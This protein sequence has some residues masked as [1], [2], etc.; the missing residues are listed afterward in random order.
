MNLQEH[1]RKIIKKETEHISTQDKLKKMVLKIGWKKAAQ[2][3]GSFDN[4]YRLCLNNDYNEFLNI[5]NN[6]DVSQSKKDP[7]LT[8][9]RLENGKEVLIYNRKTKEV[10][11]NFNPIWSF[12]TKGIG[13]NYEETQNIIY[14]WLGEV[15]NLKEI[16]HKKNMTFIGF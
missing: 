2:R 8:L 5:Y 7:D 6:L 15:Y 13:L 16:V 12:F 3:L 14:K 11:F 9:F 4:L 10:H 1:I